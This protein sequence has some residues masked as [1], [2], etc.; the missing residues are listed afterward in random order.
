MKHRISRRALEKLMKTGGK[1]KVNPA[2][3]LI[4]ETQNQMISSVKNTFIECWLKLMHGDLNKAYKAGSLIIHIWPDKSLDPDLYPF[5]ETIEDRD[6]D[7][8]SRYVEYLTWL[9]DR[10]GYVTGQLAGRSEMIRSFDD[11]KAGRRSFY[12]RS[13]N[14]LDDLDQFES[15]FNNY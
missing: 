6:P 5:V 4:Y 9:R 15:L 1:L 11:W 13:F 2:C 12:V 14:N 3:I 7:K 10:Y 8:I